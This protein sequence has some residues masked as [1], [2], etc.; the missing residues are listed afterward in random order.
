MAVVFARGWRGLVVV[1]AAPLVDE[2]CGAFA[3]AVECVSDVGADDFGD[4]VDDRRAGSAVT[5]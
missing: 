1:I 3:R 4:D 2:W 5:S